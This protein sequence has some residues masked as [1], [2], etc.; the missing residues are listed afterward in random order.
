MDTV[1]NDGTLKVLFDIIKDYIEAPKGVA[2]GPFQMLVSNI[3]YDNYTGRIAVGKI[4]RGIVKVNDQVIVCRHENGEQVKAKV[5]SL[6]TSKVL[7]E[8][9]PKLPIQAK[10][11]PFRYLKI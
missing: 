11:L 9:H 7:K 8:Q 5:S 6:Y 2:D 4:E 1:N 3:D 10:L